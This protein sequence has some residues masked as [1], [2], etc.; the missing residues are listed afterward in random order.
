MS[1]MYPC[2]SKIGVLVVILL[3]AAVI[4]V[5]VLEAEV[6]ATGD[7]LALLREVRAEGRAALCGERRRAKRSQDE[8]GEE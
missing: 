6:Y 3:I 8:D 4:C 1:V 2:K 5:D 7:V